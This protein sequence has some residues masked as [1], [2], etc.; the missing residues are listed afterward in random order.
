MA[1][2]RWRHPLSYSGSTCAQFMSIHL[3]YA[4]HVHTHKDQK[5]TSRVVIKQGAHSAVGESSG[6]SAFGVGLT[7]FL[8]RGPELVSWSTTVSPDHMEW[9]WRGAQW[10]NIV[11]KQREV[12]P[13]GVTMGSAVKGV[14]RVIG[15]VCVFVSVLCVCVCVLCVCV[16]VHTHTPQD[17]L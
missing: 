14:W 10:R 1:S 8:E 13:C 12:A 16:S 4:S 2:K 15:L 7:H 17:N 6:E 5:W 11:G 9:L 3:T